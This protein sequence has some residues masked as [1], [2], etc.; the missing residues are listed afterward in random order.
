MTLFIMLSKE[1]KLEGLST[2]METLPSTYNRV[3]IYSV[4]CSD[5]AIEEARELLA[6][7]KPEKALRFLKCVANSFTKVGD[8]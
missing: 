1:G 5:S 4:R 8:M 6:E 2:S 7:N 3:E